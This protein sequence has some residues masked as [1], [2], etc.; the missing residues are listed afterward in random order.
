MN[1][2]TALRTIIAEELAKFHGAVK[3]IEAD[4]EAAVTHKPGR[5]ARAAPVAAKPS[6]DK[7]TLADAVVSL[8]KLPDGGRDSAVAIL[9]KHGVEKVSD[10]DIGQYDAVHKDVVAATASMSSP[11]TEAALV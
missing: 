11:T 9:K 10:L 1:L 5:P 6:V 3:T 4:V 8:A 7:K 2:E